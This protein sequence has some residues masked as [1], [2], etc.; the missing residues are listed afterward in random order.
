MV[1]LHYSS[2][3][4]SAD[5]LKTAEG[6]ELFA[7]GTEVGDRSREIARLAETDQVIGF[8]N[9]LLLF[10][11][12]REASDIHIEAWANESI[13]R[14]RIDGNLHYASGFPGNCTAQWS[15]VSR[16]WR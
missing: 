12:R 1:Q 10:A 7:G 9:A 2:E 14:Y 15:P 13:V 5:A 4:S 16:S 6:L 8:L 3:E 11:I